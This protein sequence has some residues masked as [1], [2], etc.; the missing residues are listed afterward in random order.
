MV[1]VPARADD[2]P[3]NAQPRADSENAH[4]YLDAIM[5]MAEKMETVR[6]E[7]AALRERVGRTESAVDAYRRE[8]EWLKAELNVARRSWW[9]KLLGLKPANDPA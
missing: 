3:A 8:T 2:A 6:E 4:A 1:Q 9:R 5:Q 7:N